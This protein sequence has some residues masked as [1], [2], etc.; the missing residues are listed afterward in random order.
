MT[1]MLETIRQD[2]RHAAR[3]L[4]S[5]RL[6]SAA[7]VLILALGIG[8]NSAMFALVDTVLLRPLPFPEP[9]R[10]VMLWERTPTSTRGRVS[11]VNLLDWKVRNRTF[12]GMAAYVP[13]VAG[14]VMANADGTAET[15]SRQWV[16]SGIFDVLGVQPRVG[17]T[18]RPSDDTERASVV[19]LSEGFW[20]ARF[21]AD[22]AI[23]GRT[24]RLDGD[25][26]TVVGVVPDT[27]Q[28]IGRASMWAL[29]TQRFPPSA[30]PTAPRI[31]AAHAIGRLKP[32]APLESAQSDMDTVAASLARD[33]P[34]SNANRGITIEPL[35]AAVFGRELQVT[36][37]LFLGVVGLVLLICC[38]N[39]ANL[40]LTRATVRRRE[41]ALRAALGAGRVRVVRQLLTESV[42]LTTI[43]G[44]LGIAVGVAILRAAPL[45]VPPDILPAT[46]DLGFDARVLGFCATATLF[47]GLLFGVAPAWQAA[48]VPLVQVIAADSRTA[49]PRGSRVRAVIVAGQVAV[50]VVLLFAAGLLLRTLT[51]LTGVDR[52][53]QAE[54][55]LSMLVD[56]VDAQ[57]GDAA[58]L[59][60][61]YDALEQ[62]IRSRPGVRSAG[63]ATT[64]PLGRSYFGQVTIEV[65]G[66]APADEDTRPLADYQIASPSYFETL[67]LPVV[68][69]RGFDDRDRAGA[70]P[71]CLVNEAFV[72]RFFQGRSPIGARIAVRPSE[73]PRA[74]PFVREIV[75]VARQVKGRADEPDDLLQVYV[76]L[77]QNTVGDI[78][79]LVRPESGSGDALAPAVRD[80]FAQIDKE[81]T[82]GVRDVMTLEDVAAAGTARHRFRAVLVMTFAGLALVLAM[83]GVFGVLAYSVEQRI[84][85]FGVRR[86]LG[87]T[88]G[89]VLG[90][91]ARSATLMIAAG[92][93]VGAALSLAAGR[94]LTSLLF[95]VRPLDA[96]TL[97]VVAVV[98][99]VTAAAAVLAPAL[100]AIRIDPMTALRSD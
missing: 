39:V 58:G 63:W 83:V 92:A 27:A 34:R 98:L 14:M 41:L 18:F 16:S 32:D 30:P 51:N 66:E 52:G 21:D 55:V 25:P 80:A 94:L 65:V 85:D 61:F 9:D 15:V 91:V 13:N 38:A 67:D 37:L 4:A 36:S 74:N 88:T 79:L 53:Y 11:V 50:A 89:D 22:P 6:F 46:V 31:G 62:D 100:R 84:R 71:V 90:V 78:F 35:H 19:I 60:R 44:I 82:T 93:V 8:A 68:A 59:L 56:P 10:L 54:S 45:V 2:L 26:W 87:A 29:A 49:S 47:V 77:A 81:Q 99:T 17:R 75:G 7:A 12:S 72:R 5:Q 3:A 40:L 95:G 43:G 96:A 28:V 97:A 20:R 24:L 69:G 57:F 42:L 64:L 76:P 1:T 33:F 23:V 86:A 48:G 73:A 70:T